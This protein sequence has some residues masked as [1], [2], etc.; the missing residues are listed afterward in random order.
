[1]AVAVTLAISAGL[2]A[3]S[4]APEP[5]MAVTEPDQEP[6][7]AEA[8]GERFE[9]YSSERP[10]APGVAVTDFD[11]YGPDG[12]SGDPTWL[13]GSLLQAD[14]SGVVSVDRIFPGKVAK[15]EELTTQANRAGAVAAFNSSYFDI[16]GSGA[17]WGVAVQ[18][19]EMLQSPHIDDPRG[20]C[21]DCSV[22]ITESGW[23]EVGEIL[24]E[25]TV[26]LPG[27][28]TVPLDA[29]NKPELQ[30]ENGIDAFTPVWGEWTR[31]RP[32]QDTDQKIEVL[33]RDGEVAA[34]SPVPGEGQLPDG[35]FALVGRGEGATV[36]SELAVGDSVSIDYEFRS[37]DDQKLRA[38]VSG[39]QMLVVDGVALP[40][41]GA[42]S[43]PEPNPRTAIGFSKDGKQMFVLTVDGRQPE[44]SEGVSLDEL[45]EMMVEAGAYNALNL[46][47]GGSTTL[48]ARTPGSDHAELH[49]R[50]SEFDTDEIR[51]G[52]FSQR[53]VPDGLGLFVPEGSGKPTGFWV[54]TSV[55][56]DRAAGASFAPRL[57]TDRV[58]P[59]L[60][61]RLTA[62]AYDEMYSPAEVPG[63]GRP[64]W[65]S[66]DHR[67]GRMNRDGVF[68]ARNPGDAVVTASLR[69][70]KGEFDL[71]VLGELDHIGASTD[72]VVLTDADDS[73]TF[74]VVGY[75]RDGY[76]APIE[77]SDVDLSYDDS[78]VA[79]TQAESGQFEVT[80]EQPAGTELVEIEV[81]GKTLTLPITIGLE[82][83]I[84]AD[85]ENA[86]DWEFLGVR[87][88][89]TAEATENG[90]VGTGL[91]LDYDFTQQTDTTRGVG[92]WPPGQFLE[93]PG[94][95]RELR[96][97][98]NT[99]GR[100]LRARVEVFDGKGEVLTIQRGFVDDPG[101]QEL[102]YQVPPGVTYPLALR[103]FYFNELEQG[104]SYVDSMVV[105]QF[106]AMVPPTVELPQPQPLVDPIV[107]AG[108]DIES[109]DWK[110]AV[111]ADAH[112]DA[113]DPDSDVVQ[114]A[115][116]TLREISET[117]AEMVI[118]N[119]NFV[120]DG[121]T[122]NVSFARQVLDEELGDQI[123]YIYV[124]GRG[125]KSDGTLDAFRAE[126]GDTHKIVDHRGTR[127]VLLDTSSMSYR[128][129][130]WAQLPLVREQLDKAAVD[131]SVT[132]VVI[133]QSAP[134]RYPGSD[135]LHQL[136][137]RKE[138]ATVEAWL[139]EFEEETHKDAVFIGANSD[140][141]DAARVDGVPQVLV[142]SAAAVADDKQMP[143]GFTGWSLW[144]VDTASS[145]RAGS[146]AAELRPHVD[147]LAVQAPTS[148]KV[149][150]DTDITATLQQAGV[151]IPVGYPVS[152]EWFGSANVHIGDRARRGDIAAFDPS[153]GTLTALRRGQITLGVAV[154]G[155]TASVEIEL[156][157]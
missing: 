110:F 147:D 99:S 49:N 60:T 156:V 76:S 136:L 64:T 88:D 11:L 96:L 141:F 52:D 24:F 48:V 139:A 14:L 101:W 92:A 138:A 78:A 36:L 95:P 149:G 146:I 53:P 59:G 18:S 119:G 91:K 39:R 140:R 30:V 35:S 73:A 51:E 83:R 63:D 144:G 74:D 114:K 56:P 129:S 111:L 100:G 137:D 55:D 71:T 107:A 130:D 69:R 46:D 113:D 135:S 2:L 154:N 37:A 6:A 103:R 120:A 128:Q 75:D 118:V 44:F 12:I 21:A 151:S 61:R 25:G 38:A 102:T 23:G 155:T 5:A 115:R 1:M 121:S 43:D 42:G 8:V 145:T 57:R 89:G 33:V 133:A 108:S 127:F 4:T 85:F 93:I 45:A 29:I 80:A 98:A 41:S 17:P 15:R 132:S 13:Q 94:E 122:E 90:S 34:I 157:R 81:Q 134:L 125:E 124:P 117:G 62:D 153:S 142:G 65:R 112:I 22:M 27:G 150:S 10:V 47:G 152:A 40:S 143:G 19:G 104:A 109:T 54:E 79:I 70:A 131:D 16:N 9:S 72:Q 50:P 126:F 87:A 77:P 68:M 97:A 106:V 28:S 123:P 82:E 58:F 66:G 105:D 148:V 20:A 67:V 7:A 31:D 84:V 86:D 32:T 116:R 26:H 3:L